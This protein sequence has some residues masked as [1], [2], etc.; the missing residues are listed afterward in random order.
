MHAMHC[1]DTRSRWRRVLGAVGCLLAA[2]ATAATPGPRPRAAPLLLW[3]L[4]E[5]GTLLQVAADRPADVRR[6]VTLRGLPGDEALIGID[7]RVARGTLYGVTTAARVVV[8]DTASGEV[9]PVGPPQP[10]ALGPGPFGVDFNPAADRIRLVGA[11]GLNARLHPD[12]GV[13]VDFD[14]QADGVQRDPDLRYEDGD[15]RAGQPPRIVAAGYTYNTRDE[16]KTTNYA[17][18][19]AAGTLVRQGSHEDAVPAVSPNLGRLVTIG[20]LG[21]GPLLDASFDI[22]DVGNEAL[23]AVR[24]ADVPYTRLVRIDLATGRAT[25]V[26]RVG[27]GQ[28][29]RGLA[30]E[31]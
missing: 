2:A 26:D 24:T 11:D 28:P 29:L 12:T 27:D 3:A 17:L 15:A 4:T 10:L 20:P 22:S 30:I 31:P 14:P 19:A 9:R 23:A 6:Q 7:Y 21:L 13:L 16:R 5:Q 18:D 1:S 25:V 8:I